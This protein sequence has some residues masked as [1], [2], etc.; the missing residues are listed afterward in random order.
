MS[1]A[2]A[3]TVS[4]IKMPPY[5]SLLGIHP[6]LV[7]YFQTDDAQTILE[8]LFSLRKK[9]V[10]SLISL[11]ETALQSSLYPKDKSV[12]MFNDPLVEVQLLTSALIEKDESAVQELTSTFEVF[13]HTYPFIDT[14]ESSDMLQENIRTVYHENPE[15]SESVPNSNAS[16]DEVNGFATIFIPTVAVGSLFVLSKLAKENL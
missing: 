5:Q 8:S 1:S 14:V 9:Q 16:K 3:A 7:V 2:L 6:I 13:T 10:E 4:K 12:F 11:I 15:D